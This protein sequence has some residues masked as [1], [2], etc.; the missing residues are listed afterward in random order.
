MC[1]NCHNKFNS[2]NECSKHLEKTNHMVISDGDEDNYIDRLAI[3]KGSNKLSCSDRKFEQLSI[4]N[5]E[6]FEEVCCIGDWLR[7]HGW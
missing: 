7:S 5:R 2:R 6:K 1:G 3:N 4:H